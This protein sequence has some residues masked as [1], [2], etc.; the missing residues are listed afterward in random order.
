MEYAR[1]YEMKM[2]LVVRRDLKLRRGKEIAQ[3]GHAVVG[4]IKDCKRRLKTRTSWWEDFGQKKVVCQVHSE[5]E[6]LDLADHAEE[7]GVGHYL[8]RDAGRT[9]VAPNTA[10][11][12]AIGPD[13]S[14]LIDI[15]TGHL[16]LY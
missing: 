10:T 8:V 9:E 4:A 13:L 11:V 12:L 3:G 5:E 7:L 14:F 1:L 16:P 15:I 2:V 6:L